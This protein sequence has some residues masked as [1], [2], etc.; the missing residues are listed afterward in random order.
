[1]ARV[2]HLPGGV[3]RHHREPSSAQTRSQDMRQHAKAQFWTDAS[4]CSTLG[5]GW[6]VKLSQQRSILPTGIFLYNRKQLILPQAG[7]LQLI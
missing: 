1:M 7:T 2:D 6:R 3:V 5:V 4:A